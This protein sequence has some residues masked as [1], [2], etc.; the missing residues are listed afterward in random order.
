MADPVYMGF[1]MQWGML[2]YWGGAWLL[3]RCM[4]GTMYLY[5]THAMLPMVANH[6]LAV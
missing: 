6:S 5:K 2:S 1:T 4:H 3:F